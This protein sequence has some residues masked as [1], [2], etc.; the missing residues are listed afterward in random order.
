MRCWLLAGGSS[1]ESMIVFGVTPLALCGS[2]QVLMWF[3]SSLRLRRRSRCRQLTAAA[4]SSAWISPSWFASILATA[5]DGGFVAWRSPK[6]S[7][8]MPC[9]AEI[10]AASASVST[11]AVERMPSLSASNIEIISRYPAP[12]ATDSS[13]IVTAPSERCTARRRPSATSRIAPHSAASDPLLRARREPSED[14]P[15]LSFARSKMGPSF[16]SNI[17]VDP[18]TVRLPSGVKIWTGAPS[19]L[20][21]SG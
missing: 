13:A 18:S 6:R 5:T 19:M 9:K 11:S 10:E 15:G 3:T 21:M 20:V 1:L 8:A 12:R 17:T 14:L 2:A 7:V 4:A 16:S